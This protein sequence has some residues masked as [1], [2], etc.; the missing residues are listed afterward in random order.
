MHPQMIEYIVEN[1]LYGKSPYH[2]N[3][4]PGYKGPKRRPLYSDN[5]SKVI[6]EL[7]GKYRIVFNTINPGEDYSIR[8]NN[9]LTLEY[10][11]DNR[12]CVTNGCSHLNDRLVLLRRLEVDKNHRGQG[13]GSEFLRDLLE[14]TTNTSPKLVL[15]LFPYKDLQ[16]EENLIKLARW[17][18]RL[19][20]APLRGSLQDIDRPF[21]RQQKVEVYDAGIRPMGF[22]SNGDLK[23]LKTG[24][25]EWTPVQK[26]AFSIISEN[27]AFVKGEN[28]RNH[29]DS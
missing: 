26:I 13:I 6:N 20:F 14:A 19:G 1:E 7:K 12:N 5:I 4:A 3:Y 28:P 27:S 10:T 29:I 21:I 25:N 9:V 11:V 23:S 8:V 2:D 22:T 24:P 15:F 17:Y 16:D 18:R